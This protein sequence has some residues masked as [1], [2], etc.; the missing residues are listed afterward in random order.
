[1]KEKMEKDVNTAKYNK[2]LILTAEFNRLVVQYISSAFLRAAR[3]E[4]SVK[5]P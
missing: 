4:I 1:M 5:A 3:S 2:R